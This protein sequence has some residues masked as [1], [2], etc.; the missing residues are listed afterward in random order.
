MGASDQCEV[1]PAHGEF[2][3]GDEA[4]VD[5]PLG[6]GVPEIM[7]QLQHVGVDAAAI[8]GI[9]LHPRAGREFVERLLDAHLREE[10]GLLAERIAGEDGAG[11]AQHRESRCV[12]LLLQD[13]KRS[14]QQSDD[15]ADE[16]VGE[17]DR[18]DRDG[19]R[20]ELVAPDAPCLQQ[21]HRVRQLPADVR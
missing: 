20:D 9:D 3:H 1:A 6:G 16:E 19:E 13:E 8:A 15:D 7:Q 12:G 11:R 18:H 14:D 4:I 21:V 17:E 5:V 2:G 10:G